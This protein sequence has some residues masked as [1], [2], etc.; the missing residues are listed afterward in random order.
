MEKY[1]KI[2]CLSILAV[3]VILIIFG[4]FIDTPEE[5]ATKQRIRENTPTIRAEP[6]TVITQ[7]DAVETPP[8]NE[9]TPPKEPPVEPLEVVWD[10]TPQEQGLEVGD[11]ITVIGHQD[12]FISAQWV[13]R[14]G[15]FN[16]WSW[17]PQ[18][19]FGID[20]FSN[21]SAASLPTD[22]INGVYGS[23][24]LPLQNATAKSANNIL[25]RQE[26]V[27]LRLTGQIHQILPPNENN[28]YPN[29]SYILLESGVNIELVE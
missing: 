6:E 12:A 18:D 28:T 11:W 29:Q 7:E 19:S 17:I 14:N 15:V 24:E 4:L 1:L 22:R 2:G 16:N 26:T 8:V 27:I 25:M 23:L 10:K 9:P 5:K 20:L 21:A 3:L 13:G